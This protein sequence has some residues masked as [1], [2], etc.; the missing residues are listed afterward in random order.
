MRVKL[1]Q[2]ENFILK[3]YRFQRQVGVGEVLEGILWNPIWVLFEIFT[4]V[5]CIHIF[6]WAQFRYVEKM[7][8]QCYTLPFFSRVD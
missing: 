5:L 1:I 2:V 6:T 8:D 4:A 7:D 3:D